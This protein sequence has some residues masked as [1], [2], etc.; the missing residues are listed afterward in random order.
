VKERFEIPVNPAGLNYNLFAIDDFLRSIQTSEQRK[1]LI[2]TVGYSPRKREQYE[3]KRGLPHGAVEL[4]MMV[5]D[6][7][8]QEI[9]QLLAERLPALYNREASQQQI[10]D[11][12][13]E[14]ASISVG[15]RNN[16]PDATGFLIAYSQLSERTRRSF[17]G[18]Y[19]FSHEYRILQVQDGG[20]NPPPDPLA[21]VAQFLSLVANVVGV[22]NLAVYANAVLFTLAA[23]AAAAVAFAAVVV[24]LYGQKEF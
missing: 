14:I 6:R 21:N 19:R 8:V 5:E 16:Y 15:L 17:Q 4:A 20:S 2:A 12:Y 13:Q 23:A 18:D 10:L 22:V 1:E 24:P 7:R 3:R 11:L 9:N